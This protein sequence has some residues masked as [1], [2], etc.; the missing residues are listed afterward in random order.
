MDE[1]I[2]AAFEAGAVTGTIPSSVT[3]S[4]VGESRFIESVVWE[5]SGW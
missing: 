4:V 3:V 5:K 2:E 1:V